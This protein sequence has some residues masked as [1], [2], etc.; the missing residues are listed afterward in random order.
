MS[1]YLDVLDWSSAQAPWV[2][3]GLRRLLQQGELVQDDYAE[4]LAM[5]KAASGWTEDAPTPRPL[6]RGDIPESE[7]GAGDVV[8]TRLHS[9]RNV[10]ALA[11]DQNLQF[12][13]RGMTIVYGDNG[14]GKSGFT[15]VL[16]QV[17]R[18]RGERETVLS[19]VFSPNA[20]V[21]EACI[22]FTAGGGAQE[23]RWRAG[24]TDSPSALSHV[25]VFDT[26]ASA[27]F[28]EAESSIDWLPGGLDL[29]PRW[30]DA[31]QKI[32]GMMKAEAAAHVAAVPLPRVAPGTRAAKFLVGL[33]HNTK[34]AELEALAMSAD[35]V[36]RQTQL[37]EILGQS[38]PRQQ[39]N[40]MREKAS[41]MSALKTRLERLDDVFG[42]DALAGAQEAWAD[43][44]DLRRALEASSNATFAGEAIAG[45]GQRAW[46]RL[47]DAAQAFAA[48]GAT[49][50]AAF[51]SENADARCVLCLQDLDA[52]AK[53]RLAG[54]HSFV[55][56]DVATKLEA[57]ERVWKA[58]LA[59]LKSVAIRE[60]MDVAQLDELRLLDGAVADDVAALLD[61]AD[62]L[63]AELPADHTGPL[64]FGVT[65][66]AEPALRG[67]QVILARMEADAAGLD[68]AA[69]GGDRA[70]LE[71]EAAEL[72][73]RTELAAASERVRREIERLKLQRRYKGAS[74]KLSTRGVSNR[75]GELVD[76][77]ITGVLEAAFKTELKA[78]RI[79]A[80]KAGFTKRVARAASFHK[81]ST[82]LEGQVVKHGPK[83]VFSEGERRAIA[84]AAF[85]AEVGLRPDASTVVF[86]DPVCSMDHERRR[87][88]ADRFVELA[89]RHPVVVFTHDLVFL[90]MLLVAHD[91]D[92]APPVQAEIRRESNGLGRCEAHPPLNA[93]KVSD[94]AARL[95]AE[96]QD[97]GALYRR[98][99]L[100]EYHSRARDWCGLLRE[101][102]ER[103]VE[104]LLLNRVVQRFDV[105]VQTDRL[106][107]LHD[108]TEEDIREVDAG[109]SWFSREM[110]G[111]AQAAAVNAGAPDPEALAAALAKFEGFVTRMRA[112]NRK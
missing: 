85:L 97:L 25:A 66:E 112:R 110:R 92:D 1:A 94:Q 43:A 3:D 37:T 49:S 34:L 59:R 48:G 90:H 31:L 56:A 88:V 109:M 17:C 96:R 6:S 13:P 57:A 69:A 46:R 79:D 8:L 104:E 61:A 15:R 9:N 86:D 52:S 19:N 10:N 67:I 105:R 33:K 27:A 75:A 4:L 42:T 100:S 5:H 30:A 64:D 16:K 91:F 11:D 45:I 38:N 93:M 60:S 65:V 71:Q 12:A 103:A 87:Y 107:G 70:N 2:Q 76:T 89:R 20:E 95:R 32:D 28:V 29:L 36:S 14:A 80:D 54:F 47:W 51:P 24:A 50:D 111:H 41:R 22:E 78:L 7:T 108:I 18:A 101:A 77:H 106:R 53:S 99:P 23:A 39:A 44:D 83:H 55:A 81:M 74:R 35:D 68:A 73:A 98:G 58:T 84:L 63:M 62:R 40:Q 21:P 26:G 82:K 72:Q 102:W